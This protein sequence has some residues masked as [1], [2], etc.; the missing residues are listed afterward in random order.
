MTAHV[1]CADYRAHQT[2]HRPSGRGWICDAWSEDGRAPLLGVNGRRDDGPGRVRNA[3][4]GVS[5][6]VRDGHRDLSPAR[7]PPNARLG[8]HSPS[9]SVDP[10]KARR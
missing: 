3:S 9:A 7:I 6:G 1:S 5:A 8:A 2:F 4:A 10:H